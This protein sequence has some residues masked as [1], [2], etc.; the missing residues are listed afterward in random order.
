VADDDRTIGTTEPDRARTPDGVRGP[1]PRRTADERLADHDR[2]ARLAEELLPELASRLAAGNLGE[3]EIREDGWRL[4]VRR[5]AGVAAS[6]TRR[7]GERTRA[8][9]GHAAQSGHGASAAASPSGG[10]GTGA[11][12]RGGGTTD[13][14]ASLNGSGP[15]PAA[16]SGGAPSGAPSAHASDSAAGS[17]PRDQHRIVA[18]SPAVG[19]FHAR[20]EL[21][22]GSRVRSGERI[23]MV[24]LLGVPQDVVSPEDGVVVETLAD[25]GDGVEYGQELV[26]IELVGRF[27]P[28]PAASSAHDGPDAGA[29]SNGSAPATSEPA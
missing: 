25:N 5:P 16:G 23:A 20:P 22:A 24:D 19:I 4:R 1:E 8:G 6:S 13:G 17:T 3:I 14:S 10:H 12:I 15:G 9:A 11:G 21:R 29:E 27:G 28:A 26:I 7:S 18:T 2:I